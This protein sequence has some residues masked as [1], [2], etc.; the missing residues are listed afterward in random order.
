MN[1]RKYDFFFTCNR[2]K[3]VSPFVP[4]SVTSIYYPTKRS[5]QVLFDNP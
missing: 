1:L 4:K 3:S 5:G 2:Y